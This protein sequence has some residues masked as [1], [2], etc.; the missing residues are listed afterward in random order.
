V[1]R[2]EDGFTTIGSPQNVDFEIE[3]TGSTSGDLVAR[4][5]NTG[6]SGK[7]GEVELPEPPSSA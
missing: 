7:V 6:T 4:N 3:R 2:A 1:I 5:V